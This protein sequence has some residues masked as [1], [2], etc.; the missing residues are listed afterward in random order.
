MADQHLLPGFL[1]I[2]GA[3]L[4]TF[5]AILGDVCCILALS[6]EDLGAFGSTLGRANRNL[7][8]KN[9]YFVERCNGASAPDLLM[10]PVSF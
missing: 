7:K 3:I 1:M 9:T 4:D 8:N 10:K 6:W 2:V 5:E